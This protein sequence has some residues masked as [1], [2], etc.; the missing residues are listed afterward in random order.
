[1][2]INMKKKILIVI[3]F[4]I[5]LVG[6]GVGIYY[7]TKDNSSTSTYTIEEQRWMEENKNKAIDVY[8][9]SDIASLTLSGDGLFFDF[10]DF[11][12]K[13]TSIKFNP[14]AYQ[15]GE[16]IDGEYSILYVDKKEKNDIELY[17]DN[18][19]V[20]GKEQGISTNLSSL[21]GLK[22]GIL[23]TDNELITNTIG[24]N[25]YVPFDTKALLLDALKTGTVDVI[26][27]SKSLY[28]NDILTNQYHIKYQI[29][30]ITRYYVFRTNS[31]SLF[32][33]I[34]NK[35]YKS[36]IKENY[37]KDYNKSLLDAYVNANSVSEKELTDMNS[38][39]YTYGYIS[40]GIYDSEVRNDLSGINFYVLKGFSGFANIELKYADEYK[41]LNDLNN[42]LGKKIDLYF[43]NTYYYIDNKDQA[44]VTPISTKI[45]FLAK[46]TSSI[47]FN[48]LNYLVGKKIYALD[49][50]KIDKYLRD[51]GVE[52]K[53]FNNYD[54]ISKLD[55]GKNSIIA[56]E[57][58]NYE[59]YKTRSLNNYHVV[60]LTES[61]IN[62]GYVVAPNNELFSKLL[63]FYLEYTNINTVIK[64]DSINKYEYDGLNIVLLLA[65]I[66]LSFIIICQF[67]GKIKNLII[68]LITSRK[69]GLSKDE[70][71][72]YIDSLTS[73]KNRAYL[74]DN[75][76]AWDNSE[77]YPQ[78]I[79][80]IDLNN[81]SY[82]NDNYGH[83]E[84][85]KVI[86][87][88]ANILIQTQLPNTEI[89]RTDGNE[90]LVY[91]VNYEE[92]KA[93]SYI[94]KLKKEFANIS[95]GF[96]AAIGYS[97]IN[98]AIKTIDDAVNEAVLDMKTNK[99]LMMEEDK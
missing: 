93:A 98:D 28:L 56:I 29:Y 94:R 67:L 22:I 71:M 42:D 11:I 41:S 90:F 85:D 32:T 26:I 19:V 96:G 40:N 36:Y 4:L 3:L 33:K 72:K 23:K 59:Y 65:V 91:M 31:E 30:D 46:N 64:Y 21:T 77:V 6:V 9:P 43:D 49:N 48:N 53:H 75:I 17:Q 18:Y 5:V 54:E 52:T 50:S 92:K 25:T 66:V 8:I 14:V 99:E 34:L 60:Y 37:N 63:N 13:N 84:G 80:V 20:I 35:E 57:L 55:L 88:A 2:V 68:K 76:E 1:M 47:K 86:T 7:F 27:G 10:L 45:V 58:N 83:E 73:L 78:V 38:K 79:I 97:I 61:D 82:I 89:I 16:E 74:N 62:Y 81:V 12:T 70:K 51:L 24:T 39:T 44:S 15:I 87:E 95:H 69:S